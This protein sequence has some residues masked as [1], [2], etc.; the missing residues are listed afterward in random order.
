MPGCGTKVIFNRTTRKA[1]L[2]TGSGCEV[3]GRPN[4]SLRSLL[5]H[6]INIA[7]KHPFQTVA[8]A[9]EGSSGLLSSSN[10][11]ELV[12]MRSST[13]SHA[14]ANILQPELTD[15]NSFSWS[16]VSRAWSNVI[17]R[18]LEQQ[19][20]YSLLAQRTI[21]QTFKMVSAQAATHI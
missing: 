9:A 16:P 15:P 5:L 10:R 12:E 20:R 18:L 8:L 14:I 6:N 19:P 7:S 21:Q 1:R 2:V 3:I 11:K 17:H 4:S 13:V